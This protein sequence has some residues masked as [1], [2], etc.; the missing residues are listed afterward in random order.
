MTRERR[1]VAQDKSTGVYHKDG[2]CTAQKCSTGVQYRVG[3]QGS[4]R[5]QHRGVAGGAAKSVAQ[6]CSTGVQHRGAPQG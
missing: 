5:V 3:A 2:C 4:T 1:G 6:G